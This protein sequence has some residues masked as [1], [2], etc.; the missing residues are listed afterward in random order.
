[1]NYQWD[2]LDLRKFRFLSGKPDFQQVVPARAREISHVLSPVVIPLV[3][4][5][6][7]FEREEFLRTDQSLLKIQNRD[8]FIVFSRLRHNVRPDRLFVQIV[9]KSFKGSSSHG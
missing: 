4:D 3:Q 6:D 7:L 2:S 5:L 8:F 9:T 1:V